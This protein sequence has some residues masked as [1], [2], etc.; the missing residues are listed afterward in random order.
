[1]SINILIIVCAASGVIVFNFILVTWC[2]FY[3][4]RLDLQTIPLQL[5]KRSSLLKGK[6]FKF[7]ASVKGSRNKHA[8]YPTSGEALPPHVPSP[9][10]P[11]RV[12]TRRFDRPRTENHKLSTVSL[13]PTTMD[14]APSLSSDDTASV[15]SAASA[16][17]EIHDD[18]LRSHITL[19]SIASGM[20][21]RT[22]ASPRDADL[23]F[24]LGNRL[25]VMEN[26]LGPE[27]YNRAIQQRPRQVLSSDRLWSQQ[28]SWSC[29]SS[30]NQLPWD[31]TLNHLLPPG[32][33][34]TEENIGQ[35][36]SSTPPSKW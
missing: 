24:P 16:P 31:R 20:L 21:S 28:Q 14:Y 4:R 26:G 35:R 17:L 22:I 36:L 10:S 12:R 27:A 32:L 23:V 18:L 15:Y 13:M 34:P 29:E 6:G 3:Q 19:G 11:A 5:Q 33:P 9:L 30:H 1:M 8:L 25:S 2:L 7:A